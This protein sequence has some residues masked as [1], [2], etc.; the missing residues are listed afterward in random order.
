MG[1]HATS[2]SPSQVSPTVRALAH[3]PFLALSFLSLDLC[4][5]G[6]VNGAGIYSPILQTTIFPNPGILCPTPHIL[7]LASVAE[8]DRKLLIFLF[9]L[10]SARTQACAMLGLCGA[11]D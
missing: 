5:F 3:G 11:G 6:P 8:G 2:H 7:R 10:P 9:Y 4:D 1:L